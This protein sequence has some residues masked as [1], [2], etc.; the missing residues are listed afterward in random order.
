MTTYDLYDSIEEGY[1][2]RP[3]FS[4]VASYRNQ[5]YCRTL[6]Y[7]CAPF[8]TENLKKEIILQDIVVNKNTAYVG[9]AKMDLGLIAVVF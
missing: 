4:I 9:S 5:S 1:I 8:I 7:K 3:D 2:I 6:G